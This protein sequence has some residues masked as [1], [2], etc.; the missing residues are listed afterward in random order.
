MLGVRA[1]APPTAPVSVGA[2]LRGFG[3][4]YCSPSGK[5]LRT[6]TYAPVPHLPLLGDS[7]RRAGRAR[8][9]LARGSMPRSVRPPA[10]RSRGR[11]LRGRS[12]LA[13]GRGPPRPLTARARELARLTGEDVRRSYPLRRPPGPAPFAGALAASAGVGG[14]PRLWRKKG[15]GGKGPGPGL[16]PW[17]RPC[18]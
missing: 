15:K 14:R 13:R 8:R 4:I 6:G 7:G 3:F 17:P 16:T 10:P 1:T 11:R 12:R 18:A 2:Y 5:P 9:G